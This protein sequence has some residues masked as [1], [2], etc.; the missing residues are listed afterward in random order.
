MNDWLSWEFIG[1]FA[2]TCIVVN[3]ITQVYKIVIPKASDTAIRLFALIM[4]EVITVLVA[5][6]MNGAGWQNIFLAVLNGAYVFAATQ[7][8]YH[9]ASDAADKIKK[10]G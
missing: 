8:V 2:G 9:L 4:S 1:T 3:I 6:V 10:V 5:V 7:G